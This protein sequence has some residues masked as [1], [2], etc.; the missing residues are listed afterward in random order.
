MGLTGFVQ[1]EGQYE[2][3]CLAVEEEF[4]MQRCVSCAETWWK[5]A[6]T[7]SPEWM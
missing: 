1:T 5:N 3:L 6:L 7:I 2:E 4:K